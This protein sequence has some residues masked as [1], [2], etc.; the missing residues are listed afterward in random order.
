[1]SV[2]PSSKKSLNG[3]DSLPTHFNSLVFCNCSVIVLFPQVR[4]V[5]LSLGCMLGTLGSLKKTDTQVLPQ[6]FWLVSGPRMGGLLIQGI[7]T[8]SDFF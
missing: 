4:A 6:R 2:L 8:L 1:M 5:V 7:H 3:L